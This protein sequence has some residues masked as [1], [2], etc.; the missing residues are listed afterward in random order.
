[1]TDPEHTDPTADVVQVDIVSDVVCPWCIIGFL[2]L[3]QGLALSGLGAR[4]R[5]HPFQLNPGMGPEGQNIA[6]HVAEKYGSTP[7]QSRAAR[8]RLTSLGAGLGFAINFTPD[9]RIY[10]T[11]R[12]HQLLD[13]AGG[14][15]LQ[16]PLKLALFKAYFTDQRDVSRDEVLLDVAESVGLDR[17]AAA[18]VLDSGS[19]AGRV[20]ERSEFWL[21]N[22]ISGVPAMV[23]DG[24]YLLTGAQDPQ[25]YADV[26]R[27]CRADAA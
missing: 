27:R 2:Q 23:F 21:E 10:N 12:A 3:Q 4:L 17:T 26:L 14:L 13:W 9:S 24:R 1:M 25:T 19:H 7:E 11:F 15:G 6:E 8:E 20:K 18:E 5:W 16:H 22:G